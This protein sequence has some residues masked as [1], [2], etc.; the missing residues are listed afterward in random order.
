MTPKPEAR[1]QQRLRGWWRAPPHF[2][3]KQQTRGHD[4]AAGT[5]L[6]PNQ[7]LDPLRGQSRLPGA[8]RRDRT[9]IQHGGHTMMMHHVALAKQ[10]DTPGLPGER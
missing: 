1:S 8:G 2:T 5:R 6:E 7:G 3:I 9:E 4:T 10:Q